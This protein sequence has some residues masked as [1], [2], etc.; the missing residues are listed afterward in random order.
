MALSR[1]SDAFLDSLREVTDPE[2]Q[3]LYEEVVRVATKEQLED[4][5]R[6]LQGDRWPYPEGIP[7][8]IRV[9]IEDTPVE[10]PAWV[11]LEAVQE[12]QDQFR[13]WGAFGILSLVMKAVPQF[14][15]AA[16]AAQVFVRADTFALGSVPRLVIE[17]VHL[18][19]R[20]MSGGG[21]NVTPQKAKG[22]VSLQKLR[23]HHCAMRREVIKHPEVEATPWDP[24]WGA[25]INQEDMALGI[26]A[27]SLFTMDGLDRLDVPASEKDK[28]D[29]LMLWRII[30]WLLGQ[31][32]RTLPTSLADGRQLLTHMGK[33]QFRASEG[34]A[35]LVKQLLAVM[36]KILPEDLRDFPTA[37][38]RYMMDPLFVEMLDVPPAATRD[39]DLKS[40]AQLGTLFPHLEGFLTGAALR[41]LIRGFRDTKE[42]HGNRKAFD[43]PDQMLFSPYAA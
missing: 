38:M 43:I 5:N 14:L 13:V 8:D 30:G 35:G 34:G 16:N 37:M 33:R 23:V 19:F 12:A 9:F 11:D 28:E 25:P 29:F 31:D 3:P 20:I 36:Q 6:Y 42:R 22:V 15:A 21:L 32:E 2:I 40:A 39:A 18:L 27:L 7:D 17:T 10:Y 1:L 4:L 24:A 41:A 26:V